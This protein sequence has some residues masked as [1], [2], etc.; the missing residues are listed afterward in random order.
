MAMFKNLLEQQPHLAEVLRG[1]MAVIDVEL[2]RQ[3]K[4]QSL[5]VC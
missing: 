3:E 5:K 2:K 1:Q 4:F